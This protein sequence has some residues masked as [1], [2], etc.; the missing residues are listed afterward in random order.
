VLAF[1]DSAA[2]FPTLIVAR[3]FNFTPQS[4]LEFTSNE[5]ERQ[6]VKVVF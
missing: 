3:L 6:V 4:M 5:T 1:N 2:Q